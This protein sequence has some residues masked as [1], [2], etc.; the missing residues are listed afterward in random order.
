VYAKKRS[1]GSRRPKRN[2]AQAIAASVVVEQDRFERVP[3]HHDDMELCRSP[4]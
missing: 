1:I 2:I 3:V 4:P